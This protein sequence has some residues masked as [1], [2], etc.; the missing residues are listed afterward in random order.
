MYTAATATRDV[1]WHIFES[2]FALDDD[3]KVRPLI[4]EGYEV[5]VDRT[6]Y[7]ITIRSDVNFHNGRNVKVDDVVASFERWL[8][9]SV[10]GEIHNVL[11]EYVDYDVDNIIA[12]KI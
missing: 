3:Y 5:S 7:T 4:A 2:L 11:I 12:I 6:L 9:V 8:K 10:V 1:G